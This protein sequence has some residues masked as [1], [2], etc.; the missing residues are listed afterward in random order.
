ME[1]DVQACTSAQC[2]CTPE[3]S[4]L[5][6]LHEVRMVQDGAA[7]SPAYIQGPARPA[8]GGVLPHFLFSEFRTRATAEWAFG[9]STY[10]CV[11]TVAEGEQKAAPG[12]APISLIIC[13]VALRA[14]HG[15]WHGF[16]IGL[17]WSAGRSTSG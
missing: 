15:L 2:S 3:S 10:S 8:L 14:H 9:S 7:V 4:V 12:K 17:A 13:H 1:R 5:H 6:M 11:R 16:A